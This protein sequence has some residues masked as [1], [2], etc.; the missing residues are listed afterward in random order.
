[1]S[2]IKKVIVDFREQKRIN[3]A[4]TFFD[5]YDVSVKQLEYGDF[6]FI[7]D[8][9]SVRV[10]FEYKTAKD[11]LASINNKHIFNQ[12]IRACQEYQYQFIIVQVHDMKSVMDT[13]FFESG[14]DMSME[15]VNGAVASLNTIST[16]L[17]GDTMYDCFDL[18]HR[19]AVKVF[20]DK[21]LAYKFKKKSMNPALNFLHCIHGIDKQVEVIVDE[22]ELYS[23]YDLFNLTENDLKT[24]P[25]IG[26][27]KAKNIYRAIHGE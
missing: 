9:N 3:N 14:V 7:D 24:L 21:P 11:F 10:L 15:Q 22:F 17:F 5:D 2:N 26:E 27:A 4:K 20:E 1:M 18:M 23:L 12:T 16:V 19:M 6:L 13:Y 8:S 25:N